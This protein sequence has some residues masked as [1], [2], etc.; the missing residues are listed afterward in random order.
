MKILVV[1]D[2][3]RIAHY[4]KLGLEMKAYIVDLATD[5]EL[6]LDLALS[7]SYDCIVL[8]RM[9]PKLSGD[10]FCHR[11]RQEKVSTPILMLTAKSDIEDKVTGLDL[12]ADDYLIK[13]FNFQEFLA[14]IR[15]LTRRRGLNLVDQELVADNLV[16]NK[17]NYQV[18]RAGKAVTLTKQEFA[19]LEFLMRHKNQVF[20]K[21]QLAEKVWSYDSDIL[22]N[23]AQVYLGY[24]RNKIDKDFSKEKKLILTVRGFG[25]KLSDDK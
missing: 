18:S 19:L 24:L 25:Y 22:P 11:L 7:E 14:R 15:A 12:G 23:T 8:D 9:L 5:G 17:T 4:L 20:S 3:P 21:E 1:E 6:G 10:E 16:L 13:P 2:E